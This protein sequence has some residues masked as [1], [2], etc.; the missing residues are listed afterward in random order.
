MP[1]KELSKSLTD[2]PTDRPLMLLAVFDDL[3]ILIADYYPYVII[4][5]QKLKLAKK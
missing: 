5:F 2:N 4:I 3:F 1:L